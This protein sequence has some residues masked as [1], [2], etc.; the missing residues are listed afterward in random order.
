MITVQQAMTHGLL[1]LLNK[2]L[3]VENSIKNIFNPVGAPTK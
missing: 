1:D 2:V 3:N